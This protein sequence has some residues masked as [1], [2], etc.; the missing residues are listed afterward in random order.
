M[1]GILRKYPYT[2]GGSRTD[3]VCAGYG[4]PTFWLNINDLR[5]PAYQLAEK[6]RLPHPF[7][8]K[9]KSVGH[10]WLKR[11]MRRHPELSLTKPETMYETPSRAVLEETWNYVWD[12]IKSCPWGNL[13][14]R[15]RRHPE[16]S[17]RKPETTHES[18]SRAALEETWNDVWDAIKSCPW[19]NLKRRMR[20]HQELSLRK[21]ETKLAARA[22]W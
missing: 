19:G 21:P 15:M 17:S 13:K 2:R 4:K 3:W 8:R 16:L 12:A 9:H 14:R 6:Y 11:C 7:N 22:I 5:E 10:D 1:H 20:R 18:P